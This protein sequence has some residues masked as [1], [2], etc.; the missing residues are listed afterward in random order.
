MS[1]YAKIIRRHFE[2]TLKMLADCIEEC[3]ESA[4]VAPEDG[5]GIWE[6]VFHASVWLETW[7]LSTDHEVNERDFFSQAALDLEPGVQPA[8]PR[9]QMRAFV[10]EVTD[11]CRK[12]VASANEEQWLQEVRIK[13]AP[14]TLADRVITQMRHVQYHC[15]CVSAILQR[16]AGQRV[17]WSAYGEE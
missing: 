16:H 8:V 3:P 12:L 7:L 4:W 15:G 17:S 10:R 5:P 1:V 6:H 13:D 9:E 11:G 2:P 14:F